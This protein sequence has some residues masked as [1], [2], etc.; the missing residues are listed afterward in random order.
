MGLD[1][2]TSVEMTRA[3]PRVPVSNAKMALWR[4]EALNSIPIPPDE[5]P[6]AK[7]TRFGRQDALRKA[8]RTNLD[9]AERNTDDDPETCFW[10]AKYARAANQ[11]QRALGF[12]EKAL[13]ADPMNENALDLSAF[14]ATNE[15]HHGE[16]LQLLEVLLG[17]KPAD[18]NYRAKHAL[19]LI[20]NGKESQGRGELEK[21]VDNPSLDV[22]SRASALT[23]LGR[24]GEALPLYE[25]LAEPY[26]TSPS[27]HSTNGLIYLITA[28]HYT[29]DAD[30]A[31]RFYTQLIK[32]Q[33]G[34]ATL[35]NVQAVPMAKHIL[36]ALTET[37]SETLKRHPELAP[38]TPE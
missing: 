33:P 12:L 10:L 26:R 25:K 31:V 37:L 6:E 8:M 28:R 1:A 18:I 20:E 36:H 2:L 21:I 5:T 14:I 27:S 24:H 38:T 15:G 22:L 3:M 16:A 23:I 30:A 32:V 7:S 29:G 9:F 17:I 11:N 35:A 4:Q 19:S 13:L 34:A